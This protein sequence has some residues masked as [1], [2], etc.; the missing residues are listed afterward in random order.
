MIESSGWECVWGREGGSDAG[1]LSD[2]EK[3]GDE[4]VAEGGEI[5]RSCEVF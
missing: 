5:K 1:G 4:Q 2:G 3:V